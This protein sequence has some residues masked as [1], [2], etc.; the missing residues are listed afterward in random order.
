MAVRQSARTA[1]RGRPSSPRALEG[2]L[3]ER[4]EQVRAPADVEAV[5]GLDVEG[6]DGWTARVKE[7][8]IEVVPGLPERPDVRVTS[9]AAT[10]AEVVSGRRSGVEAFLVGDLVVRGNLALALRFD[11][12]FNPEAVPK[13]W[14]RFRVTRARGV[15]TAYLE[16]GEGP[17]VVLLHGLGAT[18]A[19]MLPTLWDLARDHRVIAPDLP[20]FG[21]SGKPIRA[22]HA[23][24][25]SRWLAAFL[26]QL[27]IGR[28][29]LIGNSMGGRVALEMGLRHPELVNRMVLLMPSPAFIRG[30]ELVQV[31]RY[32]RPELALVPL[33]FSHHQVVR[34]IRSMFAR[35][36]R[37]PAAW[38][39]AAADEF[40]RVFRNPR[41][42][43]AFFSA[44]RQIYLE[45]PHGEHG[46]WDRL[47]AM[48]RPALFLWGQRDWLVPARFARHVERAL[49]DATSVVLEDCGHV[50]QYEL[51]ER[52]HAMVR[53]F[54]GAPA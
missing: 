23:G 3:R 7:G 45:E 32:L 30:R 24:F 19:S 22:Y 15:R 35:P 5:L 10:L 4:S 20:G 34:S 36:S 25:Y 8:R 54:L 2:L 26:G 46:F 51:P 41:G 39:D 48:D 44:A 33:P 31:V 16:A 49:P 11:S 13:E 52:T 43:V 28:A 40:L 6:A 18:N 27:G 1:R 38:F 17:P 53:E 29:D 50:P 21:D 12:L 9:G 42:R 14:P 37:L 47:P